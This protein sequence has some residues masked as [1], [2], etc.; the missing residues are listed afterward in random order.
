[1]ETTTHDAAA[2][3]RGKARL[4]AYHTRPL[5]KALNDEDAKGREQL[6]Q[7]EKK[8]KRKRG[9]VPA[10]TPEAREAANLAAARAYYG[11]P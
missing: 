3:Q 6:L 5:I 11:M 2:V 10:V 8:R 4:D 7:E 9:G 1:M